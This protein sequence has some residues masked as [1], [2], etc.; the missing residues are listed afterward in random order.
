MTALR[1]ASVEQIGALDAVTATLVEVERTIGSLQAARDGLLAVGAR[2]AVDIA[3]ADEA[4]DGGDMATR[5]VASEFGAALRMSDRTIERR[6]RRFRARRPHA[7][8]NPLRPRSRPAPLRHS[9]RARL[10][11]PDAVDDPWFGISDRAGSHAAGRDPD[12]RG[13][14]R[15][16]SDRHRD[17]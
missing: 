11:H 14:R 10:P 7:R 9:G 2:L 16:R 3:R 15:T 12:S 1:D 6:V 8:R 17:G 4:R 13:G 5:A